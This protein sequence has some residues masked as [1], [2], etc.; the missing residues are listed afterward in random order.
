MAPTIEAATDHLPNNS[1]G[2]GEGDHLPADIIG[3]P[4]THDKRDGEMDI[5]EPANRILGRSHSQVAQGDIA[6]KGEKQQTD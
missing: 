3:D 4:E 6:E 5:D 2:D 1:Q